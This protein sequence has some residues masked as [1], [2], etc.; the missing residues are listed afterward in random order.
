M[1]PEPMKIE[2]TPNSAAALAKYAALA[3]HNPAE[4]LNQY[5]EGNMVPLFENP[6][7][8]ELESHLATLEYRTRADAERVVAWME[9]RVER[10]SGP[11][12]F[13]AEICE[14]DG[15]FWIEATTTVNGLTYPV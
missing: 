2:L 7:S 10:S 15:V 3:G 1:T 5:L 9:K 4:F 12:W 13:E 6:R 14:N 8:G 11:Y